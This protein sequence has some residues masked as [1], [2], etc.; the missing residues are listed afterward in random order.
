MACIGRMQM[1]V[2]STIMFHFHRPFFNF[3]LARGPFKFNET[4]LLQPRH[5]HGQTEGKPESQKKDFKSGTANKII[6]DNQAAIC[7]Q[8][9]LPNFT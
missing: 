3:M 8:M 7:L 5:R 4:N 2:K 1:N 6:F 9:R